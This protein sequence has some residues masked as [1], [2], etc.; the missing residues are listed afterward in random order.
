MGNQFRWA[1]V[2]VLVSTWCWSGL[3]S[4][5]AEPADAGAAPAATP[6]QKPAA[7]SSGLVRLTKDNDLW[8][9]PQRKLVVLD[10]YVCLREGQLEMFAC[11]KGTKEHEAI[12]ATTC[13]PQFVHAGLLAVGAKAG[14]PATWDP[15]YK[16]AT[17]TVIEVY[18]LWQDAEGKKHKVRAQEWI[19][20]AKTQKPMT[21]EWVFAGS[22]FGKDEDT[23]QTYYYADGG[24]FICVSNFSSAML[25]IPVKSSETNA[26]LLF[27]ANTEQIPPLKTKVRLVLVPRLKSETKTPAGSPPN[28]AA[29]KD[30]PAPAP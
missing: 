1:F 27:V 26:E 13:K 23:G 18:V 10:G 28:S 8:I 24:D 9:D 29:A 30:A 11:P 19:K 16:P 4:Q 21:H 20:E 17:G 14:K 3:A 15:A 6:D 12:V 22:M 25:D 2:G 5:A 7:A